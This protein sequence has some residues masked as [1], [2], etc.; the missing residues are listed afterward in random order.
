MKK[1]KKSA[2]LLLVLLGCIVISGC[3]SNSEDTVSSGEEG[4]TVEKRQ[5]KQKARM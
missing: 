1:V 2:F 5:R 4:S 3:Q